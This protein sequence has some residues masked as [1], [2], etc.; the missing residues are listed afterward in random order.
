MKEYQLEA[1]ECVF[2]D[3]REE[4]IETARM[5]GMKGIVFK[6]YEQADADLNKMLGDSYNFVK[7]DL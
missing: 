5:L 4:N 7:S 2:I 3:D 6:T 1:S